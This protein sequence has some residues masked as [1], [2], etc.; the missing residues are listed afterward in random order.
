MRLGSTLVRFDSLPSTND[1][2]REMAAGGADE[3]VSVMARAQTAGRGRQGR[4]WSSPPGAGL[5][6][7]VILRPEMKPAEATVITF[8]AA[9]AVAETLASDFNL[10]V[11]IKWP[12]DVMAGRRKIS[13]ILVETAVEGEQL[14]YAVL[15]IG[16]NLN[17]QDFPGELKETATSLFIESGGRV[18]PDEFLSHLT[19]RLEH[20]YRTAISDARGVMDRWQKLSSYACDCP[21]RVRVTGDEFDAV[22]R[23]LAASGALIIELAGGE[24]REIASGEVTLR[25]RQ[26]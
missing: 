15:G 17:Q 11:D 9:V 13:G 6:F 16:V 19:D 14:L 3:G 24:R 7:S 8:A 20:W 22:T 18:E 12:N 23:G 2:A 26:S 1:L 21:V 4:Q 5:Y 10:D 25:A